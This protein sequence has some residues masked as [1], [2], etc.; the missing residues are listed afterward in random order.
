MDLGWVQ[1]RQ[2]DVVE[3]PKKVD[4][5]PHI[6]QIDL[7][8]ILRHTLPL[9]DELKGKR[10]FITGGTGFFGRWLLE[11]FAYA[12]DRLG[13]GAEAVV[14][15][16]NPAAFAIKAPHL[17]SHPSIRLVQGN[18]R[19]FD[20]PDG[21]FAFIIH[22]AAESGMRQS[23]DDALRT[24]ETL[25]L[26]THR[27]LEFAMAHAV[28]RF[29]YVSSGAVYGKQPSELERIPETYTGGPDPTD[30]T[31]AYGEGKRAAEMLCTLYM[32]EY[33][34]P[35]SV[36][37]CFA[38]AGLYLP[39]DA[40]FAMGN[41][42][43]DALAG[44]P[45]RVLG[46]G[47]PYRSYLYAADL[48]IWLWTILLKGKAGRPYNVGSDLPISIGDLAYLI[49]DLLAPSAEIVVAK[50]PIPGRPAERLCA[51]NYAGERRIGIKG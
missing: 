29:I 35:I 40:H 32:Q 47:T 1:G 15:S 28:Q 46:D 24:F 50:S 31:S 16:R 22:A 42:I 2:A 26:G 44:G 12:N 39:L 34:I 13:L 41:F 6:N 30:P 14:L 38:F 21:E 11:S 18:V 19:T 27:V 43:R 5:T 36:A 9:W 37:R 7:D 8:H 17:A 10:I 25:T 20:F 51:R 3:E 49:R 4:L 48:A 23:Q 33:G 45:I